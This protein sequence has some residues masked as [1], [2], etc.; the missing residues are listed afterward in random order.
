MIQSTEGM[1]MKKATAITCLFLDVGGVLLTDGWGRKFRALA[2]DT[3]HLN[4]KEME[5]RHHQAFDVYE[6]GKMNL[7]H[8]LELVVFEMEVIFFHFLS[9]NFIFQLIILNF[10][11]ALFLH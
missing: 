11:L 9:F 10:D 5:E 8:Y 1:M 4:A 3:F 6:T 7:E 2:A